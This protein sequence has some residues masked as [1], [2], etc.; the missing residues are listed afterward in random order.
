MRVG[1]S[2][3]HSIMITLPQK[4]KRILFLALQSDLKLEINL[5]LLSS[6]KIT[7]RVVLG[8]MLHCSHVITVCIEWLDS[9]YHIE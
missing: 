6:M 7:V 4:V 1:T 3:L 5:G 9:R 2:T 8:N